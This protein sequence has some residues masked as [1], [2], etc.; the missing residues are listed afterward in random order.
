MRSLTH[1]NELPFLSILFSYLFPMLTLLNLLCTLSHHIL[2][3][4]ITLES[5]VVPSH[6]CTCLHHPHPL[7]ITDDH[8]TPFHSIGTE[9]HTLSITNSNHYLKSHITHPFPSEPQIISCRFLPP[10]VLKLIWQ[11]PFPSEPQIVVSPVAR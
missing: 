9:T 4:R 1:Y 5:T 3:Y 6:P 11:H 2:S 7:M 10:A 8:H